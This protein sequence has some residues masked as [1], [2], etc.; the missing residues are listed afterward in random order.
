MRL[1]IRRGAAIGSA[2]NSWRTLILPYLWSG[3]V[4]KS[5]RQNEPWDSPHNRDV[6][7]KTEGPPFYFHCCSATHPETETSYV[8]IVGPNTISDGPHSAR[9][10]DI[11]DGTTNT[12]MFAEV[13]NSGIHW[14]EP[15]DLDF[16]DMNF[17]VNDPK[18]KGIS[19]CHWE[20]A[21]VVLCDGS[22][23]CVGN[24]IAPKL[25]KALIT[26]DGGED[27]SGFFHNS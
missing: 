22:I 18:S 12:I 3:D 20:G 2:H 13:R 4:Y 21:F 14:A 24:D 5:I 16:K 11:K 7:Q 10:E 8:M 15:R 25:L 19:T 27:V 26:I 1:F 9:F 6:F 17:R 23:R